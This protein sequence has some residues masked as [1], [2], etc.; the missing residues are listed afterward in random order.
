MRSLEPVRARGFSVEP[1]PRERELSFDPRLRPEG[2]AAPTWLVQVHTRPRP[3]AGWRRDGGTSV[4]PFRRPGIASLGLMLE[5]VGD[6][7]RDGRWALVRLAVEGERI[8]SAEGEGLDRP[9][10]GLTLLEAAA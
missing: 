10:E 9:L 2:D 7:T 4:P 3:S 6:S 8:V 1:T 5:V